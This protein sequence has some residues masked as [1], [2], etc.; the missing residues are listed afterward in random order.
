MQDSPLEV[1]GSI[2]LPQAIVDAYEDEMVGCD[3]WWKGTEAKEKIRGRRWSACYRQPA[4]KRKSS[5]QSSHTVRPRSS[6]DPICG[7]CLPTHAR[8]GVYDLLEYHGMVGRGKRYYGS[9]D[10]TVLEQNS[11]T[12]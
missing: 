10:S 5:T 4:R 8:N 2:R 6:I 1:W 3:A 9:P 11:C 12:C 7:D